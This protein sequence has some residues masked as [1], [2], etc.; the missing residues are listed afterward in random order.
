MY[1]Q[2]KTILAISC[3]L[4]LI[5][6]GCTKK[7]R[8][9]QARDY[10][11]QS[12]DYYQRAVSEYQHLID[13]GKDLDQAYFELGLLY[14]KHSEY[15]LASRYLL[16]TNSAQAKKYRALALYRINNFTEA[17][18]AF[19]KIENPDSEALYYYGEVCEKL[20][21]YDQS[22][23]IYAKITEGAFSDRARER[24]QAITKLGESIYLE[25][26]PLDL[27]EIVRSAPPADEYPNAGALILFCDEGMQV[28]PESTAVFSEHFMIKIL[29]Q[30]GKQDFSEAIISYD[31][32]YDRVELEYAR[33]IRPDGVVVPVGNRHIRDVSKYLNFPLY[34]NARAQIISF[35][36][37]SEGCVIE[38]KYKIYRNQLINDV[39]LA[40]VYGLQ[41]FEPIIQA[42]LKLTIP[43]TSKPLHYKILNSNY[44]TF[45][46]ELEPA[47]KES[48]EYK[49]YLWEFKDI[50]AIIPEANMPPGPKI[51]PIIFI[52][53]F[54]SWQE[55]YDWWSSLAFDKIQADEAIKQKVVELTEGKTEIID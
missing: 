39:D 7:S 46:A 49:E 38:Y 36:E 9:E 1:S 10:A 52:S 3:S 42:R 2:L 27:Q 16:K 37:V 50:P 6:S 25:N 24:V 47:I 32:T 55:V 30:R 11:G 4:V 19:K 18:N 15:E 41:E 13:Q 12:E 43:K 31:S 54:S 22:L 21:L 34:S 28:T 53:T 35:P 26:L 29:N 20:N 14:Y 48:P 51:N 33:T 45:G 44:N 40:F 5:I 8:F 17:K 23:D